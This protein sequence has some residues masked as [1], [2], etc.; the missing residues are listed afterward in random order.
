MVLEEKYGILDI[1]VE[2]E[3]GEIIDVEMQLNDYKNI[4]ERTTFYASK[5]ISEQKEIG[6]WYKGLKKVV[7]IAL[8]DYDILPYE[9]YVNKTVRVLEKHREHKINNFVEYY[10]I[11]LKKFM[12]QTPNMKEKINQ[13]LAFIDGER[14][15]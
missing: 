10:Y 13:W 1:E 4:E 2:L 5:K 3:S 9:E 8:L 6:K 7:I 15:I 14:G 11:E 12:K